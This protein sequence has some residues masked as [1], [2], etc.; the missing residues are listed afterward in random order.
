MRSISFLKVP[1]LHYIH[2]TKLKTDK[3]FID[4]FS[5]KSLLGIVWKRFLFVKCLFYY[6]DRK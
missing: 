2:D 3:I 1:L 6:Q 5:K 4:D